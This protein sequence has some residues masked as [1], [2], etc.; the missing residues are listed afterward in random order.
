MQAK[1]SRQLT[2]VRKSRELN[3][4]LTSLLDLGI[5]RR[6]DLKANGV[7]NITLRSHYR[8]ELNKRVSR[9]RA[10]LVYCQ[11]RRECARSV[12]TYYLN[13]Q[14]IGKV[15]GIRKKDAEEAK[16]LTKFEE[17]ED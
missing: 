4:T 6:D 17:L 3:R 16:G 15:P 9:A 10:G 2:G 1:K 14:Q 12:L 13:R 8:T 5:T 11:E 7:R